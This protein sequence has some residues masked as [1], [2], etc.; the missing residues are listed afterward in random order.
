MLFGFFVLMILTGIARS[1]G[2]ASFGLGR[3]VVH[4]GGKYPWHG[5]KARRFLATSGGATPPEMSAG[6]GFGEKKSKK[7]MP[8]TVLS[9]FLGAGKTTFLSHILKEEG[10]KLKFGLVV[11]DM[12]TV[13]VD[14][15]LIRTQTTG[16]MSGIDTMELSNGY[17][18]VMLYVYR[19]IFIYRS[20][21]VMFHI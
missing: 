21:V 7:K 12:A 9:G 17:V 19:A 2:L 14:S 5:G 18:W 13:N 8:I 10:T 15:K 4:K 16:D 20:I 6:S 3:S 11:N 1:A